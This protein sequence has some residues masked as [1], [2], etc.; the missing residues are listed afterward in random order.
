MTAF[1][2]LAPIAAGI[3][4]GLVLGLL[5]A[6]P[7]ADPAT[8]GWAR[9]VEVAAPAVANISTTRV[10]RTP[11]HP[12]C[13][14]PAFRPF[15]ARDP[16]QQR[17]MDGALGSAV[18]VSEDGYLLTNNHV[19]EGADE[20]YVSLADGRRAIADVVGADAETDLAVLRVPLRTPEVITAA[21]LSALRV[22]DAV[23]AIGNPFGIGQ[24]V[25]Q[26]IVSALGRYFSE[27][28]LNPYLDFIQTDAAVNPGNSGGALVN[29]R[30]ELVGLNTMIFSSTGANQGIGFAIPATVALDVLNQIVATGAVERG[31]LGIDVD[32]IAGNDEFGLRIASIAP[33]GPA[34]TAG[35]QPGDLILT[36]DDAPVGSLRDTARLIAMKPPGSRIS[37]G[38]LRDDARVDV[39]AVVGRRPRAQG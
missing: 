32:R 33:G 36:L 6:R 18:V 3:A 24:T 8:G 22:G 17:R 10:V 12:V 25:S 15:C 34:A 14:L 11:T 16:A 2:R 20:I 28:T 29:T 5:L 9:A 1:A 31:W 7:D 19:I 23:L 39:S 26:G 21:D 13:D 35:L 4:F 37:L 30:G 27:A 38:V